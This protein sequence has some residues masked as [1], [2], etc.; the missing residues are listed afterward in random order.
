M[1]AFVS[2]RTADPDYNSNTDIW[3]IEAKP[4]AKERQLTTWTGSDDSPRWSPDGTKIAYTRS[5]SPDYIMYDQP[6][7]CAIPAKGGE[8]T[9]LSQRL[10]ARVA[11]RLD[12]G[13][14]IGLCAHH[15][16]RRRY[17]GQFSASTP[18]APVKIAKKTAASATLWQCRLRDKPRRSSGQLL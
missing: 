8:P 10:T 4:G 5:T 9:L 12:C 18:K 3:I 1:L 14:T 6:V 13:R 7:L 2:N 17:I 15:H 16:D 11:P